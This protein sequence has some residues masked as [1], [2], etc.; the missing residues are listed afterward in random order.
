MR[1]HTVLTIASLLL[2]PAAIAWTYASEPLTL[3]PKSRLWINGT[4]TVRA[5]Q[6]SATSFETRV[7]S[8]VPDGVSAVLAGTKAVTTA[9]LTVPAASMDCNNGTM[10]EHMRKA[11]K[12][13]KNPT[14]TFRITNYDVAKASEG[15]DG[16]AQGELTLGGV[17]KTITVK[18]H[19]VSQP[20]GV[21]RL[22]GSQDIRMTQFGLKPPTLMLGTLKVDEL[23]KVSFDLLLKGGPAAAAD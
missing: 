1:R 3:Q 6:C 16:T 15:V 21:L 19:A 18:A 13:D 7:E 4:S 8:N 11:L 9:Q 12:A 14:I 17:T 22:T 23:V 2:A 20:G 5:F 10:N